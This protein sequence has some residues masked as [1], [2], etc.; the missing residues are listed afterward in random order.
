MNRRVPPTSNFRFSILDS[1][2][3]SA[4][5]TAGGVLYASEPDYEFPEGLHVSQWRRSP[6]QTETL[7]VSFVSA[8]I[9]VDQLFLNFSNPSPLLSRQLRYSSREPL[10]PTFD[11]T[12]RPNLPPH[13]HL[14][15]V[16]ISA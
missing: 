12:L 14:N 13:T 15:R 3:L 8:T 16:G 9:T 7:A 1:R 5:H 4:S 11:P 6:L 10:L 2:T